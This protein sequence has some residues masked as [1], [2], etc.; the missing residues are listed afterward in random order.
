MTAP[1]PAPR[2]TPQAPQPFKLRINSGRQSQPEWLVIYGPPGIGKS[3]L[4]ASAPSPVFIDL[5]AGT[6]QLDVPRIE[7]IETWADLLAAINALRTE[8]HEFKSVVIDTLDKAEWLCW[9]HVCTSGGKG[10][11]A[12]ARIEEIGGGFGKGYTAA[13]EEFRRLLAALQALRTERG[14]RAIVLAHAKVAKVPNTS[15]PDYER[16]ELKVH[17]Q[18][19]GVFF[20]AS[21]AVLYAHRDVAVSAKEGERV[22][23]FGNARMLAT[24]EDAGFMAKNRFGMPARL[25]LSWDALAE[26][27][28]QGNSPSLLRATIEGRAA[29]HPD[30]AVRARVEAALARHGNNPVKLIEINNWLAANTPQGPEATTTQEQN[31]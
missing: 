3:T 26:A 28:A 31:Q 5:E 11:K 13:Y 12:V 21:D 8:P 24:E 6:S 14:M 29:R 15:G 1:A 16:W 10:G 4:G 19:G 18:I 9:V 17:K 22:R 30:A 27:I 25:P 23:G 20:E 2:A 7:G